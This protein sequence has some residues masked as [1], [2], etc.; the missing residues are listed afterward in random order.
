[1]HFWVAISVEV[2]IT[3]HSLVVIVAGGEKL[4]S[5]RVKRGSNAM[6]PDVRANNCTFMGN[7]SGFMR[8]QILLLLMLS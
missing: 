6:K 1:M 7:Q 3:V 8:L 4:A 5:S 2:T